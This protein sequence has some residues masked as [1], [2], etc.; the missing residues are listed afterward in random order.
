[1][2]I[3]DKNQLRVERKNDGTI[4]L[5]F[6][7]GGNF[8]PNPYEN[9]AL[10]VN[11]ITKEM[12]E[13]GSL[14]LFAEGN[15]LF[16]YPYK[17]R[18][19]RKR[20]NNYLITNWVFKDDSR[21]DRIIKQIANNKKSKDVQ[22]AGSLWDENGNQQ[23]NKNTIHLNNVTDSFGYTP[24]KNEYVSANLVSKFVDDVQKTMKEMGKMIDD[25]VDSNLETKFKYK[26]KEKEV[27]SKITEFN[28]ESAKLRT[29][30]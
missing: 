26:E 7:L 8:R 17:F 6:V 22:K 25:M 5:E 3:V 10:L 15:D 12:E 30:R 14:V 16:L 9:K 1:M 18:N 4:S 13:F 11:G 24:N 19:T 29:R 23:A 20:E 27:Q 2:K 21:F 28:N